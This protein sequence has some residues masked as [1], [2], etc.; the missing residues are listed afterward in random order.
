MLMTSVTSLAR[1]VQPAVAHVTL[2]VLTYA[3]AYPC[4]DGRRAD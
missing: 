4:G 2:P 3:Y 1:P